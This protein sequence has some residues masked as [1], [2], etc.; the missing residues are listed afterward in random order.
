MSQ[1]LPQITFSGELPPEGLL[2]THTHRNWYLQGEAAWQLG[3]WR[4]SLYSVHHWP[5][6]GSQHFPGVAAAVSLAVLLKLS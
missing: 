3:H 4:H 6:P 1:F 2:W 5:Q